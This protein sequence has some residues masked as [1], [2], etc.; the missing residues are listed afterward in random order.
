MNSDLNAFWVFHCETN[1]YSPPGMWHNSCLNILVCG[2]V[3][4]FLLKSAHHDSLYFTGQGS[5]E[6][7]FQILMVSLS[8]FLKK[9]N[10]LDITLGSIE[11]FELTV[12]LSWTKATSPMS[13][14]PDADQ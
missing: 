1:I 5:R 7:I 8:G 10:K 6:K 12:G 9:T 14:I 2:G 13:S 4:R 11:S 3:L